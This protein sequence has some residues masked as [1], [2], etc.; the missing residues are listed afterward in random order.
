MFFNT[1]C[2]VLVQ[3]K[4]ELLGE[5]RHQEQHLFSWRFSEHM[6]EHSAANGIDISDM[7]SLSDHSLRIPFSNADG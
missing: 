2:S 4:M 7:A 6:P 1:I 3:R 5:P